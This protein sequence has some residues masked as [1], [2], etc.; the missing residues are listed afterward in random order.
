MQ[1][2]KTL[3]SSKDFVGSGRRWSWAR[4]APSAGL[5]SALLLADKRDHA[6]G[7]SE[8]GRVGRGEAL[9]AEDHVAASLGDDLPNV[10]F[11]RREEKSKGAR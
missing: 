7:N 9:Q 2:G 1:Q 5:P 10:L 8:R 11:C 4:T 6:G 3:I